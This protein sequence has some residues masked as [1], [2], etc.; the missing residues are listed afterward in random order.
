[1][2][3]AI[4]GSP[5][6]LKSPALKEALAPMNALIAGAMDAHAD[7]MAEYESEKEISEA[8]QEWYVA[9]KKKLAK[10]GDMAALQSFMES[11]R[12]E[13]TPEEPTQRRFRTEDVT[14]EK[15]AELLNQNPNGIMV[16]RD[17]LVGF[18]RS[19]DRYGREGDRQFYLEGWNGDQGFTVD[20]IGRGTL[21][22]EALCISLLGGIQPGPLS[23]YVHDA[24]QGSVDDDGL[25]QRFQMLVWPDHPQEWNN[26]DRAPSLIAKTKLTKIFETANSL[27]YDKPDDASIPYL[28]FSTEAQ[29]IF[30]VWRGDL[31]REVRSGDLSPAMEAH[32]SKY[33]SLFPSLAL[34]I[35]IAD[36]ASEGE[37]ATVVSES[38]AIKARAWCT[39]LE[40]HAKR[41]Y[42]SA[43]RPE[44]RSARELVKKLK[45]GKIDH[46]IPT[47]MLYK[48][49]WAGLKDKFEVEG[50]LEV[51]GIL[52]WLRVHRFE[53]GGRPSEVVLLHP[54]LRRAL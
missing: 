39:Y 7:S 25:L 19:L 6:L 31:E 46:G 41:L 50:A 49:E 27:S 32:K 45:A 53:S 2:W 35:E 36:S 42:F 11:N 14:V 44:M 18:L 37:T 12:P 4:V 43:E 28:K 5:G 26:I 10:K 29:D 1:L 15:L 20:R 13:D 54:E 16:H 30:D 52:G 51:L 33:R 9:E 47:R 3:G 8:R 48:N 17:E 22:V 40:D 24:G 38:S 21:N 23:R 34:L